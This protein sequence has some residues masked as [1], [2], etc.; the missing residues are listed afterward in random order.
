[1]TGFGAAVVVVVD[2]VVEVVG[3]DVELDGADG[4]RSGVVVVVVS[5][6]VVA[7]GGPE[8]S[9]GSAAGTSSPPDGGTFDVGAGA[10]G[11]AGCIAGAAGGIVGIVS[12]AAGN[13]TEL[14]STRDS[15]STHAFTSSTG[16]RPPL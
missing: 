6:S 15:A 13:G 3:D 7:A 5:T 16:P 10:T 4:A 14:R 12:E 1:M 11:I 9:S 2:V 8:A